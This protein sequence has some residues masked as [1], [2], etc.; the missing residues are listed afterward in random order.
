MTA[1]PGTEGARA[2]LEPLGPYLVAV[3]SASES[4]SGL[5]LPDTVKRPSIAVVQ[6]IGPEIK[7]IDVGDEIVYKEGTAIDIEVDG[8]CYLLVRESDVLARLRP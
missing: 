2:R 1:L 4:S 5:V 6:A 8:K 3:D 7:A